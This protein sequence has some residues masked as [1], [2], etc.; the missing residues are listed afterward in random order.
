M[1][2]ERYA[3]SLASEYP[4]WRARR[5]R[6]MGIAALT[7]VVV[8]ATLPLMLALPL[9]LTGTN[10]LPQHDSYTVAY[11][12]RANMTDQYWVDMADELLRS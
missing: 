3:N 9:M 5:R 7:L 8:G 12:N 11:C 1:E 4:A 6:N 10:Q 2:A